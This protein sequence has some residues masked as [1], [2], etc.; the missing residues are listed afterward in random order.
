M[1]YRSR[2][3]KVYCYGCGWTGDVFDVVGMVFGL[4]TSSEAFKKTYELLDIDP[5]KNKARHVLGRELSR[6]IGRP[7]GRL[8]E[9]EELDRVEELDRREEL[10]R[11][12]DPRTQ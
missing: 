11:V 3:N 6:P 5:S 8:E 9:E 4:S 1:Q 12:E 2:A 7:I 10:E